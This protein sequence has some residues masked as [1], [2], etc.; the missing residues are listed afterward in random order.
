MEHGAVWVTY[1]PDLPAA[2]VEKLRRAIPD[3]YA[4]LSPYPGIKAPV[5]ASAW[6]KQLSL[7]GPDD[8]RLA[9]FVRAYRQGP[10]TPEP[11]ASCT[12][13]TDGSG[14]APGTAGPGA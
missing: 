10:Q 13:G 8:P 4:V 9:A 14:P 2:Q 5:V 12:G 11:G 7:S 6:G 1:S 3:T